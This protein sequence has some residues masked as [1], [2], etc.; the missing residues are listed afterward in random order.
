[1]SGVHVE[2]AGGEVDMEIPAF[3]EYD[4]KTVIVTVVYLVA[5]KIEGPVLDLVKIGIKK[6]VA[7][8]LFEEL[9]F[10]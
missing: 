3:D 2:G 5:F 7:A 10:C 8:D 6:I 1:M 4:T 9:Q